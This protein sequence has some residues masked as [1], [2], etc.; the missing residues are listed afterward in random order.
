MNLKSKKVMAGNILKTSP[1]NVKINA[2]EKEDFEQIKNA[3]TK[4][5][6]RELIVNNYI[7]FDRPKGQSRGNAKKRKLAKSK[8]RHKGQ[9]KRKGTKKARGVGSKTEWVAKVRTQRVFVKLLLE[10]SRVSKKVYWNLYRKV[11][12]GFFRSKSHINIYLR[13]NELFL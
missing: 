1:K 5:D 7:F 2:K 12:G 8:G 13:D 4:D 11:G 9:G 6:I 10:K 3:I